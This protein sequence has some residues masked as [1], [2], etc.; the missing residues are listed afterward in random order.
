MKTFLPNRP[1]ICCTRKLTN[2]LTRVFVSNFINF[3]DYLISCWDFK[4]PENA[5]KMSI[6]VSETPQMIL[7]CP[8]PKDIQ[9]NVSEEDRNQQIFTFFQLFHAST[10]T[11]IAVGD[12]VRLF[13][14]SSWIPALPR[15]FWTLSGCFALRCLLP[16]FRMTSE[17]FSAHC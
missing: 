7:F 8:Q 16:H 17:A 9:L 5:L 1:Q 11:V 4:T 12:K 6:S 10:D 15:C 14:V 3:L 13:S 2:M